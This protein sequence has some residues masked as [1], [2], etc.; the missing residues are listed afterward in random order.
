MKTDN[1]N[2]KLEGK[3]QVIVLIHG[4][5]D[6]LDY[7]QPI[8]ESL[9]KEYTIL[10]YDIRGHGKT[11]LGKEDPSIQLYVN[12]L[13]CL[14]GNLG[15]KKA[16]LLGFSLGGTIA[17]QYTLKYPDN[18]D[19]LILISTFSRCTPQLTETFKK[20]DQTLD[21]SFDEFYDAMIPMVLCPHI[22]RKYQ[23]ELEMIRK[24]ASL[25]ANTQA[26]KKT[27]NAMLNF[28]VT[29][30]LKNINNKTLIIAGKEDPICPLSIQKEMHENITNSEIVILEKTRHNVLVEGN[31]NRIS[32]L[33]NE[34][35]KG[36]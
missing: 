14:M 27:I 9:K 17:Q 12:D 30:D 21:I 5:S 33:I 2:Y 36:D 16:T 20:L 6:N 32:V 10:R 13:D 26:I 22:I 11:P 25:A 24:E 28:D 23:K 29:K 7:W 35:L 3:G 31:I 8:T 15:I 19:K 34:F 1:T 4:L 18:V